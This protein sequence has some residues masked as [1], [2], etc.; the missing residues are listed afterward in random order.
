M[1]EADLVAAEDSEAEGEARGSC[2]SMAFAISFLD[3]VRPLSIH[4]YWHML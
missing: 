1:A 4:S 2:L 3:E